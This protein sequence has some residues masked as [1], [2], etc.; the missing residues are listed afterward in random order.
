MIFNTVIGIFG[1]YAAV[2]VVI[3]EYDLALSFMMSSALGYPYRILTN[4]S[5]SFIRAAD[6]IA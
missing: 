1:P 2:V 3:P 5:F 4:I 6:D